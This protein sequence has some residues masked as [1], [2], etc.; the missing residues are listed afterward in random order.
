MATSE[1]NILVRLQDEASKA[2]A[3]ISGNLKNLE[4]QFKKMAIAGTAGLGAVTALAAKSIKDF[5]GAESAAKQLEHAVLNV[6][7]ATVEQLQA[8]SALA[9]ELERKGVLDGDNIKMGLAQLSTFGLSN[10][11]VRN[12]GGSLADLAVNQYGVNASGEQLSG[13]ANMIAK[14][15]NGQFG[16]L[17]KSGIRFTE[18][19]QKMIMYGS[20]MEKVKAINEGFAQNLKFTNDV[21]LKTTEGQFAKTAVQVGNLSESI[22][23]ALTPAFNSL[24]QAINP[25]IEKAVQWATENPKLVITVMALVAGISGLL[26]VV[27]TLGLVIPAVIAGATALGTAFTFMLGPIGLIILAIA[28]L[29][30]VGYLIYTHWEEIKQFFIKYWEAILI[31]FTGPLGLIVVAVVRN[32]ELIK[33]ST[34]AIWGGISDFFKSVWS[35]ITGI[36]D[37]AINAIQSK[38]EKLSSAIQRVKDSLAEIG[39]K[40]SGGVKSSITGLKGLIGLAD[41]GIVTKPTVAMIGEGGEPEAVIPLSKLAGMG[42]GGG[43]TVVLQGTFMTSSEQ[44]NYFGDMLATEIKRTLRI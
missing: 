19:Q 39:G 3:G 23:A 5:S 6:S 24:L 12:L 27:G 2:L 26:V 41:G 15:L 36:F 25:F 18:A 31:I 4:P 20:E 34:K 37:G 21:A 7:H 40:V 8:T 17:E 13:T 42:A 35:G 29:T 33:N 22:G 32:W 9:D 28:A 43:M 38:L 1:I 44:A 10:D 11:A 14:A 30:T 16:V